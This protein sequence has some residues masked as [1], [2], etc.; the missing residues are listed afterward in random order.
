MYNYFLS[1]GKSI[2]RRKSF[3]LIFLAVNNSEGTGRPPPSPPP[4]APSRAPPLAGSQP[5]AAAMA[6]A[7]QPPHGRP[8]RLRRPAVAEGGQPVPA[9][10]DVGAA[11]AAMHRR[12]LSRRRLDR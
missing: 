9:A 6:A 4:P 11:A 12:P 10:G 3:Y 7:S 1:E 2:P 5:A 8:G